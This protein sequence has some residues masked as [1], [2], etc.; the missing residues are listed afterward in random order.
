MCKGGGARTS[1]IGPSSRICENLAAAPVVTSVSPTDFG[2]CCGLEV[3]IDLDV[4]YVA[5][6]RSL[7]QCHPLIENAQRCWI[8]PMFLGVSS[9]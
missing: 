6:V 2:D 5:L 3:L 9:Q 4:N 8:D 1:E 7:R